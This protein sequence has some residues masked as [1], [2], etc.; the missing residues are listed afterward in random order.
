MAEQLPPIRLDGDHVTLVFAAIGDNIDLVYLGPRL[1]DQEDLVMLVKASQYGR[2]EN[3]PDGPLI[4]GLL[5]QIGSGYAGR[6]AFSFLQDEGKTGPK[7]R[8]IEMTGEDGKAVFVWAG[9]DVGMRVTQTWTIKAG[10]VVRVTTDLQADDDCSATL[11]DMT[12]AV[13]PF[14]GRYDRLTWFPGRWAREA[15][16]TDVL[17]GRQATIMQSLGG[18]PAFEGGNWLI[19][20]D[21]EAGDCIGLHMSCLGD[22]FAQ[23]QRDV[24]NRTIVSLG[25]ALLPGAAMQVDDSP[26]NLGAVE[27][28]Y[29][30][31]QDRLAQNFQNYI[32]QDV[33]P[34]RTAW[35]SRK[36]HLNS[37]EALGFDLSETALIQLADDAA[38]LAVE[39]F[40]LD[41]GWFLGRR[42]VQAGLG[43]WT[44]DPEVF[45]NGLAPLID[46][47]QSLGLDFGLWV[48]PEMISPD[49]D[50]YRAHPDWCRHDGSDNR[51]IERNQVVLDLSKHEVR[52]YIISALDELL[53]DHDIVYLKWDHNRRLFPDN[54][55]QAKALLEILDHL[56]QNWPNV[57]IEICSSGGGRVS[58]AFLEYCHR[59]W[60]SDNND[61]IERGR[62]MESW[63]RFLPLEIMGNH[64]GPSPNPITGRRT[65][66][67]F[68]C[69]VALFGH[70]GVEATPADMSA[71]ERDLLRQHIGL[72]KQWR[73][74][75]HRGEHWQLNHDDPG[76]FAQMIVDGDHGLAVVA[77]TRFAEA[78]DGAPLRMKGLEA[79]ANYKVHLP[80]PWPQ[81]AE[82]YLTNREVWQDGLML[83]GR[84]L[85]EQGL[86]IPLTHPETAWVIVLERIEQ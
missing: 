71:D 23:V 45:P 50:L 74:W 82:V 9:H 59:I 35:T 83:S 68:R 38:D 62:I 52:D 70:M 47:I 75:M 54:G 63:S 61:P 79:D 72:Y 67:D 33:L 77:Q 22:H 19:I 49:S 66:M 31:D 84:Y 44:V 3:Q 1:I 10:D 76:V 73:D 30:L 64:V 13:L 25:E 56:R 20:S 32:R 43:D 7:F 36:V 28:C 5:P 80:K 57:E 34:D 86:A 65:A 12:T 78:F 42:G 4:T 69:K 15:E 58:T 18:K 14:S 85:M 24:N 81:K 11:T 51:P 2:H 41:D 55:K 8:L 39:R 17:I 27:F 60:P 16:A 29:A 21:S 53:R 6:P 46:H 48:E 37:W 26:I 40:V